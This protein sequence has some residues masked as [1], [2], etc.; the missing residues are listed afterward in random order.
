MK[1]VADTNVWYDI[2]TG[3]IDPLQFKAAGDRLYATP[4]SLLEIASGIDE[5]LFEGRKA[6]ALAV[7]NHA[8]AIVEDV[9]THLAAL[10]GVDVPRE[11]FPWMDGFRAIAAASSVEDL[12]RGFLDPNSHIVRRVDVATLHDW[13]IN[14]WREFQEDITIA[15]DNW[16]PDYRAAR[17]AGKVVHISKLDRSAFREGVRLNEVKRH[18]TVMTYDRVRTLNSENLNPSDEQ[19]GKV[20][21]LLAPYI[22]AFCEYIIRCAIEYA[23]QEND[24]GDHENFIYLQDD[25]ALVTSDKRWVD[26]GKAVCPSRI[27]VPEVRIAT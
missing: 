23:P 17:G 5:R 11:S 22:D 14:N 7:V 27:V 10:W 15:L 12:E 2:S 18:L 24:F 13:R 26:I 16:I 4:T 25:A 21:S 6:A 3:R 8:D 1:L 9:E 20:Q 19:I